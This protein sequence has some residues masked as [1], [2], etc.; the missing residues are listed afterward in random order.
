[1]TC[2][3]IAKLLMDDTAL[4]KKD[5]K[6][7]LLFELLKHIFFSNNNKNCTVS[8]WVLAIIN[9]WK[10]A[11]VSNC[12]GSKKTDQKKKPLDSYLTISVSNNEP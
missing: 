8:K 10:I 3:K 5:T 6:R 9:C 1:M 11:N 12:I 7:Q 2:Y 4:Q